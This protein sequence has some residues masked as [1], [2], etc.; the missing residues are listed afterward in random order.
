MRDSMDNL[1]PPDTQHCGLVLVTA[2]MYW[3]LH[4]YFMQL[5]TSRQLAAIIVHTYP[6][7]PCHYHLLEE[8]ARQE[9]EAPVMELLKS[10]ACDCLHEQADSNEI[11]SSVQSF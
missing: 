11:V 6:W 2:C 9:N 3:Y 5:H 7:M 4:V 10:E 1:L 8:L